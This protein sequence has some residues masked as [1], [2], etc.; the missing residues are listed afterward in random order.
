V[1]FNVIPARASAPPAADRCFLQVN[2]WDDF[3]FKTQFGLYYRNQAGTIRYLG[4][5]KIGQAGLDRQMSRPGVP[6]EFD[7]LG[8]EFFSLGQDASYYQ[9]INELSDQTA[10][11]ILRCLNDVAFDLD[12]FDRALR[13]RVTGISLLRNVSWATVRNQFHRVALG[14]LRLSPFSFS[15]RYPAERTGAFDRPDLTFAVIPESYPP[16]NVHV[17][18]GRNGVG[19]SRLLNNITRALL[20]PAVGGH[21][22]GVVRF[23]PAVVDAASFPKA[24]EGTPQFASIVSVA[25]SAF[26]EFEP[27]STPQDRSKGLQYTYI[28]LKKIARSGSD[29]SGGL[30]DGRALATEFGLSVKVCL[31]RSRLRRW[32]RALEVLQSDPIFADAQVA[33]LASA[34]DDESPDDESLRA[35]AR[36]VFRGLSSGHKIVLL[37][38]TRLVESVEERTLVLIDEPEAH[39]H[40]PLLSAFIRALSELLINRNG[41]AIIATHSPVVLQEVPKECVWRLRRSGDAVAAERPQIETFGENVGTLTHEVFG[42]EVT[43]SGFHRMIADVV[44]VHRSYDEVLAAFNGSIGAE[45]RALVQ[46]LLTT[47]DADEGGRP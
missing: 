34:S 46:A 15:Y 10:D 37:T 45:G 7:Q 23:D 25:F 28:G 17:V 36:E 44:G 9:R 3:G 8:D 32:E 35:R 30:K 13:H 11:E 41:V 4:D 40:P 47:R 24:E 5:V 18:I 29:E 43:D 33:A 38:V 19:K 22:L 31:Q 39:L 2:D 1:L 14:G 16:S 20:S 27:L 26:D 6:V 21:E 12:L 42:L